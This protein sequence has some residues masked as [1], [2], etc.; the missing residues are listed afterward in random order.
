MLW[1]II[2][3]WL[4]YSLVTLV[5]NLSISPTAN[6]NINLITRRRS[7]IFSVFF[8]RSFGFKKRH[9]FCGFF[10]AFDLQMLFLQRD[11]WQQKLSIHLCNEVSFFTRM[12]EFHIQDA[13]A[14]FKKP[15]RLPLITV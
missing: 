5:G 1:S 4:H 9:T 3:C 11:R 10:S 6:G 12:C 15:L 8:T 7:V 13:L 14:V 2:A